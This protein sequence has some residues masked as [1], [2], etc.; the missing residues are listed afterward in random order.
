MLS[1]N[2]KV[3]PDCTPSKINPNFRIKYD[4]TLIPNLIFPLTSICAAQ[5]EIAKSLL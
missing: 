2:G 4:N 1:A 5:V 3:L